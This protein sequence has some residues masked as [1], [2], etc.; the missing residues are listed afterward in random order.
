MANDKIVYELSNDVE[1]SPN[2]FVRKDWVT[3]L[4]NNSQNYSSNQL[5]I[6]T[7]AI[8]NSSKFA[9]FREGYLSVPLLLTLSSAAVGQTQATAFTPDVSANSADYSLGLKNWFGHIFHS[10]S[11]DL[12]GSTII[13]TTPF[14]SLWNS[15]KLMTTLSWNDVITQGSSIGFF[16]DTATAFAFSGSSY[17]VNGVGTSNNQNLT[18]AS[19]VVA[20]AF[21]D[22]QVGNV[23]FVKRQQYI[24]Y[25]PEA[26]M[27][28]TATDLSF[29]QLL[30]ST[31]LKTAYKSYISS[32]VKGVVTSGAVTTAG[33]FQVSVMANIQLKHLHDF[34]N[35]ISLMKGLFFNIVLNLNNTSVAFTIASSAF[36]AATVTSALGGVCPLMLSSAASSNGNSG[37]PAGN[38]IASIA[39]G[40]KCLNSQQ[41]SLSNMTTGTLGNQVT[42]NLPLY[43]FAPVFESA[44]LSSPVKTIT[45]S[46]IY[47][48][49]QYNV[50]S[51]NTYNFLATNGIAK[52]LSVTVLPFFT[53]SANGGILPIQSP[54][55]TAAATTSPLCL[56]GN[57]N[58]QLSGQNLLYNTQLY[59]YQQYLQQLVGANSING[60]QI[61]G[62]C[63]SLIG[64]LDFETLY[65]F[66][67]VRADRALGV[68]ASVPKSV[69]ITGQNLSKLAID[70]YC[71][72]EYEQSIQVDV[73]TAQRL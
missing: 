62:L 23:G 46:D 31:A 21:N 52:I 19:A 9:S 8:S 12:N 37:L 53:A 40:S 29:A 64:Q 54:F 24:N 58:I 72:I 3:I 63:S 32:K 39:V 1:S 48:Y 55:D 18:T 38:Y 67:Y 11:V 49:I 69:A 51:Q 4:D 41:L 42:L 45:Y 14:S 15:F 57:F 56:Q 35:K 25:D 7:S 5:T 17:N 13:Q 65:N 6:S 36:S 43:T 33:I 44:Y 71:F 16:P 59:S 68:E 50:A 66:Y 30:D 70:L 28:T 60:S 10:M 20:G 26:N 73:L 27:G 61:D 2:I 47:N 22:Y 34:F